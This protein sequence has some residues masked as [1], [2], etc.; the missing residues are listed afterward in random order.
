MLTCYRL[1]LLVHGECLKA[2][3]SATEASTFA[4]SYKTTLFELLL[5]HWTLDIEAFTSLDV[6]VDF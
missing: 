3:H 6:V 2:K 1:I 5:P 4:L